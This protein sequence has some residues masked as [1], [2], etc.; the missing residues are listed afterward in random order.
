MA[1]LK[2]TTLASLGVVGDLPGMAWKASDG[3][4]RRM[5]YSA[6]FLRTA[7][8]AVG[9]GHRNK[10]KEVEGKASEQEEDPNR[11]QNT[12]PMEGH[13]QRKTSHR[14]GTADPSLAAVMSDGEF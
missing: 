5:N 12:D 13:G 11:Q 10:T 6:Q 8:E 3:K 1:I 4:K 14:V 2:R 7:W 9:E